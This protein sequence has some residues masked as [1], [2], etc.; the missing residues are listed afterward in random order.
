MERNW[1]LDFIE[2]IGNPDRLAVSSEVHWRVGFRVCRLFETTTN[3]GQR[4][5]W[6]VSGT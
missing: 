3:S 4:I 2:K 5:K 1:K 6:K